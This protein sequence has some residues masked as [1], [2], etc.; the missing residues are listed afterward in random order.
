[1]NACFFIMTETSTSSP[2]FGYQGT[3]TDKNSF[4]QF[5]RKA[6]RKAKRLVITQLVV[7]RRGHLPPRKKHRGDRENWKARMLAIASYGLPGSAAMVLTAF[8]CVRR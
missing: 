1:M 7:T 3:K 4:P 8:Y 5:G 2:R 6:R